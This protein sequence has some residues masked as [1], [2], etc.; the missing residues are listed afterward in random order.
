MLQ[1]YYCPGKIFVTKYPNII[2]TTKRIARNSDEMEIYDMLMRHGRSAKLLF[3]KLSLIWKDTTP[4]FWVE[5][6]CYYNLNSRDPSRPFSDS[7]GRD[8]WCFKLAFN[9][10]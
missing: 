5:Y 4:Q 6:Y 3:S 10:R 2:E 1:F 9:L 7:E 8:T